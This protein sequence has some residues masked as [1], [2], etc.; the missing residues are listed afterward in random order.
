MARE[1]SR[2]LFH[3][4]E[5]ETDFILI[6]LEKRAVTL[7]HTSEGNE[8]TMASAS[9]SGNGNLIAGFHVYSTYHPLLDL[10][11]PEYDEFGDIK[12]EGGMIWPTTALTRDGWCLAYEQ[13]DGSVV[14]TTVGDA[15][16]EEDGAP[17]WDRSKFRGEMRIIGDDSPH[18]FD[19]SSDGRQLVIV[20]DDGGFVIADLEAEDQQLLKPLPPLPDDQTYNLGRVLWLNNRDQVIL[21]LDDPQ[22]KLLLIDV[23]TG[24]IEREWLVGKDIRERL[25]ISRTGGFGLFISDDDV[26]RVLPLLDDA[27]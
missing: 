14:V 17:H 18:M 8:L 19:F 23:T 10:E 25:R 5:G 21:E 6:D 15:E 3:E 9:M 22:S 13:G 2:F 26:I 24:A 12:L 7:L 16:D 4:C 1:R 11:T 20:E 27:A